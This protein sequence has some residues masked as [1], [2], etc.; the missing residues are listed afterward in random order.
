M[1]GEAQVT[2]RKA[3]IREFSGWAF[4]A[5]TKDKEWER[6]RE[7]LSRFKGDALNSL[8]DIL[9]LPRGAGPDAHKVCHAANTLPPN[10]GFIPVYPS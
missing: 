8:L 6:A 5:A 3:E 9:E 7:Y 1:P 2:K 4:E 10:G